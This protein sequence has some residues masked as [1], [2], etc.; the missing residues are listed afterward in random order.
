M[1]SR[2]PDRSHEQRTATIVRLA[3][4]RAS[5][6]AGRGFV[7]HEALRVLG[8]GAWYHEEAVQQDRQPKPLA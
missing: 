6:Q 7:R 2:Q 4:V 1:E 8:S 5:R 3:D